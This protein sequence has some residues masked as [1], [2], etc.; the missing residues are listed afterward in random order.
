[1]N[2]DIKNTNETPFFSIITVVFNG[3]KTLQHT[4]DS[5]L[6][7]S[8]T[9]F[10]Y[11]IVDG[12]STDNTLNLIKQNTHPSLRWISEPDSGIY[13]AFNKG[14]K[15]AKGKLI[16]IINSDDWYEPEAFSLIKN[17]YDSDSISHVYYGLARFWNSDRRLIAVQGYTD[18][19]LENGMISHPTCFVKKETYNSISTFDTSYKIAADYNLML[20]LK[21]ANCKFHF[22]EI[23]LANFCEGGIST[24]NTYNV[25]KETLQVRYQHKLISYRSYKLGILL[26][27]IRKNLKY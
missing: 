11:I 24:I 23:V 15:M 26:L 20:T 10:E 4:I 17:A 21:K 2:L 14:I 16:G 3:E 6:S 27:W 9:N 18:L 12:G 1:M 19:F 22:M 7:Q 25:R 13:D 5:V 8:F